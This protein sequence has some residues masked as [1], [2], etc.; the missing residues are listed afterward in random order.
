MD[1]EQRKAIG[2]KAALKALVR[3]SR[4]IPGY[5]MPV[6]YEDTS[7]AEIMKFITKAMEKALALPG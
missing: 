1:D 6:I 3:L 2:R 5:V 4:I 7:T